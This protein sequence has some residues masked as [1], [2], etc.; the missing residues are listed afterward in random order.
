MVSNGHEVESDPV[1][2]DLRVKL[3]EAAKQAPTGSNREGGRWIIVRDD[4][5]RAVGRA[6]QDSGK[7]SICRTSPRS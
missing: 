2:E 5:Q 1:P 6:Q 3:I 4:V 7:R